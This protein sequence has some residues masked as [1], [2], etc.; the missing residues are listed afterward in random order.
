MERRENFHRQQQPADSARQQR[1]L[2]VAL[3]G[4][5]VGCPPEARLIAQAA[6]NRVVQADDLRCGDHA[7]QN[8]RRQHRD[9]RMGGHGEPQQQREGQAADKRQQTRHPDGG[10]VAA[11][12][13]KE[14]GSAFFSRCIGRNARPR[15]VKILMKKSHDGVLLVL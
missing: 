14:A 13:L 6:Q 5:A 1:R 3:P 7:A 15:F 9:Q 10:K 12:N 2:D 4:A 8:A 11:Q